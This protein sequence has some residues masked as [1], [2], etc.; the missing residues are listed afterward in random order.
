MRV[1][2]IVSVA[3]GIGTAIPVY[4]HQRVTGAFNLHEA[5]LAFFLWLNAIIALWE[6]CLFLRID[7]IREQHEDFMP[8]Y[9][10]RELDRVREFFATKVPFAQLFSPSVW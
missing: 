3:I 8:R 6:I 2:Q 10:G 7:L 4:L 9:R 1:Y 5:V